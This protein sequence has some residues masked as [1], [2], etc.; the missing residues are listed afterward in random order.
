[1]LAEL[2]EEKFLVVNFDR[3]EEAAR[4]IADFTREQ[5]VD[6]IIP[7]GDRMAVVASI[8][9]RALGLPHNPVDATLAASDK[10]LL[11]EA[12]ARAGV[13]SPRH[14]VFAIDEPVARVAERVAA[15]IGFPCVV[16]PLRLSASR[17]VI[18]AD[19]RDSFARA[20]TR[21]AA[22]LRTDEIR[23]MR[24]PRTNA[25]LVEEFVPGVEVALEAF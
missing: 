17:G 22:L 19:D 21:L 1:M 20:A 5:R 18:R 14:A 16:K 3:P 8:A 10:R 15:D 6:A 11:R 24:T 12:L 13:R 7:A 2:F 23:K 25:I 4:A 9:A